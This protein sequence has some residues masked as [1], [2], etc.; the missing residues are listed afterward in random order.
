MTNFLKSALYFIKIAHFILC[1]HKFCILKNKQK[2]TLGY[3]KFNSKQILIGAS[4]FTWPRPRAEWE[5]S[6]SPCLCFSITFVK[7]DYNSL[8]WILWILKSTIL[9]DVICLIHF[10]VFTPY[11]C[12]NISRCVLDVSIGRQNMIYFFFLLIFNVD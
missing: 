2:K 12:K 6:K 10:S 5:P 4:P 1:L 7:S 9:S 8:I 3:F 11:C